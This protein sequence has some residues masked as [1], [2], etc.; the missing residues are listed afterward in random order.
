[1]DFIQRRKQNRSVD[2]SYAGRFRGAS[3]P[4]HYADLIRGKRKRWRK[5]VDSSAIA[6]ESSGINSK[7]LAQMA[8][9]V[10]RCVPTDWHRYNQRNCHRGAL[11]N[12]PTSGCINAK[13]YTMGSRCYKQESPASTIWWRML[14]AASSWLSP[15]MATRETEFAKFNVR[16]PSY[17]LRDDRNRRTCLS[18]LVSFRQSENYGGHGGTERLVAYYRPS[19]M[20]NVYLFWRP[21]FAESDQKPQLYSNITGLMIRTF[22]SA[23]GNEN[24]YALVGYGGVHLL[25]HVPPH[26]QNGQYAYAMAICDRA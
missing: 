19:Q 7:K 18:S 5:V 26:W 13:N 22:S 25:N 16:V 6:V 9:Y 23:T 15:R 8:Y 24:W 3:H 12:R 14:N 1:V 20:V 4:S 21:A 17:S 11:P 10:W 2:L